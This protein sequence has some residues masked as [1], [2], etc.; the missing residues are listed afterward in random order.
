MSKQMNP[1]RRNFL[2]SAAVAGVGVGLPTIVPSSVFGADAPSE[3]ITMG[4]IGVGGRGSTLLRAFMGLKDAKVL[5]VC[6]VKKQQRD[7]AK[8]SV[9]KR[10]KS[11]SC[12]AI[13][14]FREI[15]ARDDIDAVV[16]AT[17]DHWHVPAA[18]AAVRSGKDVYVEKPLGMSVE[19]GQVLREAVRRYGRVF[20]FGTQERSNRNTRFACEMALSGRVGKIHTITVASRFSKASPNYPTQ[21]VPEWLDYDL[22]LGSAPWA[23]Y[24]D[25][26][27]RN[28]G[29][30]FHIS[31]YAL[32]FIAGCGIHTVDMA[33]WGNGTTLTGPVEIEGVGEFPADGLCDCATGWDMKL[34]YAN[35]VSM[36]FTDGKRNPL[37]VRFEG[38]DGWVFVKEGHLGGNVDANP[39]SLLREPT[40]PGEVNLPVSTHHQRNFLDCVKTRA[41]TIAPVEEAVRSDTLVQLSDIAMRLGRKLKWN[42]EEE[43]FVDD[44][45]A[46]R[47]LKRPMRPPWRL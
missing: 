5:A 3:R 7:R 19:Q 14:D 11:N 18:L 24:T 9:D 16:V 46:N 34:K 4:W 1:S 27:V 6:D 20:Q 32:G 23:P 36:R 10:Y 21:P 38:P 43:L 25:N 33:Q 35:G 28:H 12:A 30:W 22:W 41:R 26:R 39:K 42:P 45:N 40:E 47:M 13:N 17:T 15:C 37:G 2:K 8:V 29:G 44:E 31:D